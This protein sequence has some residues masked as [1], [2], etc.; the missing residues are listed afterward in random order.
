MK[1]F[2]K[3]YIAWRSRVS[4]EIDVIIDVAFILLFLAAFVFALF[5]LFVYSPELA[6]IQ[7][8]V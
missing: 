8:G 7:F 5:V 6:L 1:R 2:A 4:D 3:N